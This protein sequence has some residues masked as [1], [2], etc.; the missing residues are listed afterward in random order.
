[1]I[2]PY[3]VVKIQLT[4]LMNN[5]APNINS[6]IEQTWK[7]AHPTNKKYTGPLPKF[8]SLLNSENYKMLLNVRCY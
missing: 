6:G 4:G 5:D 1:M 8:I 2:E 7:F 3:Q